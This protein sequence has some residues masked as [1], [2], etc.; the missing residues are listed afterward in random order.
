MLNQFSNHIGFINIFPLLFGTVE[1]KD[2]IDN[3]LRLLTDKEELF[4]DHGVRSLSGKDSFYLYQSNYFRG[5][6]WI[7]LNY[8]LLKGLH[9]HYLEYEI[10]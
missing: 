7:H 3:S 4:S 8:L 6:V 10:S 1:D 9:N 5:S 2:I